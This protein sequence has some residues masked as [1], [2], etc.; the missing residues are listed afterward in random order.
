LTK[1]NATWQTTAS[2]HASDVAARGH[3]LPSGWRLD[4]MQLGWSEQEGAGICVDM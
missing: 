4:W 2:P 3:Q 1:S